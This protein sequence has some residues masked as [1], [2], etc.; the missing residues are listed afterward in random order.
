MS[1]LTSNAQALLTIQEA[2]RLLNVKISRIRSAIFN[3][4]LPY[5]KFGRLVRF[6]TGDLQTW[7]QSHKKKNK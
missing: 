2:A 1:A 4:E 6:E 3:R 7:I 5:I